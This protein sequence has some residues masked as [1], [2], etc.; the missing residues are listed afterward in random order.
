VQN[1]KCLFDVDVE[2]K[3]F[4]VLIGLNDSG[5]TS[6]LDAI[7]ALSRLVEG[8]NLAQLFADLG[9]IQELVSKKDTKRDVSWEVKGQSGD[10]KFHYHIRLSVP[11]LSI[12]AE[13]LTINGQEGFSL[14]QRPSGHVPAQVL[15]GNQV[16]R[17]AGRADQMVAIQPGTTGFRAAR[18]HASGL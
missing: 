2:F 10:H 1:F 4:T 6:L 14:Q 17:L 8:G 12:K 15:F 18:I 9:G 3:P 5:K 11:G 16:L 13:T 7:C